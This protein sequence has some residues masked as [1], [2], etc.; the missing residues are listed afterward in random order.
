MTQVFPHGGAK[1]MHL[2]KE[3]FKVNTQWLKPYFEGDFHINK[4]HIQLS[5]PG[6]GP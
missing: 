1:I 4:Q 2:E 6:V 5:I 3:T